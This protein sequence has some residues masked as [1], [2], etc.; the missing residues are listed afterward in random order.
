MSTGKYEAVLKRCKLWMENPNLD[1]TLKSELEVYTKALE[2][3]PQDEAA[4]NEIYE[5]FYK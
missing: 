5:R 1:K 4:L 3:N 2:K